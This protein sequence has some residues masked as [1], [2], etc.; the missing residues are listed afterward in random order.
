MAFDAGAVIGH[1]LLDTSNWERG[2]KTV[3]SSGLATQKVFKGLATGVAAAGAV[4]GAAFVSSVKKANE[5]QKSFAN[6]TTLVDTAQVDVQGMAKE[7]LALDGALGSSRELT[8]GLYQALSASVAPAKAVEFVADSAK[9]AKAALVDTNTAV[10]VITT[11]LNAYGLQAEEAGRVSDVLFTT[12]KR[13]KTTGVELSAT[14]G[15]I[16]PLA[17]N[18]NLSF[19]NLGASMA[20]ITR[21]GISSAE[22]TTQMQAVMT[23]LLK[24]TGELSTAMKAAG[25]ETGEAVTS[26]EN[27][28]AALQQIISK[29]D[30]SQEALAALFPNVRALRGA[31]ALT[32][33][34]ATGFT[35]DLAAMTLAAGATNEAFGKQ[36]LTFETL[37]NQMGTISIIAGNVGKVFVDQLAEGASKA[38]SGMIDF[39]LSGRAAEPISTIMGTISGSF[40]LLKTTLKP[41]VDTIFPALKDIGETTSTAIGQLTGKSDGASGAFSIFSGVISLSTSIIKVLVSQIT[42][43]IENIGNMVEAIRASGGVIGDFFAF[44]KGDREWADVKKGVTAATDAFKKFG[45]DLI[46]NVVDPFKTVFEEARTFTDRSKGLALGMELSYTS[47]FNKTKSG[48]K[49]AFYEMI[50]GQED[51]VNSILVGN[52]LIL[53]SSNTTSTGLINNSNLTTRMI[54]DN[55]E[56][57]R[58][59]ALSFSAEQITKLEELKEKYKE[60]AETLASTFGPVL[61]E[62]GTALVN[63][64]DGWDAFKQAGKSA[65]ASIVKSFAKMWALEA[66]AEFALGHIF[67]GIKLGAASVAA[68]TGAGIIE[69]LATGGVAR[70]PVIV[71]ENGPELMN[72]GTPSR[73]FSADETSA[74]MKKIDVNITN[75]VRNDNDIE[76]INRQF[77]RTLENVLR[78]IG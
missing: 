57:M 21:Q 18:M 76:L 47:A 41:I 8:E 58:V 46:G 71:G 43:A 12:I 34:G 69:G 50:T 33:D 44:L 6:V 53:Q 61:G 11:G 59:A 22:S 9:F 16:I 78:K 20:T 32:G 1:V 62:L 10:D 64:E 35:E 42:G 73:V 48:F 4:I 67:T 40:E 26:S 75:Y 65:I 17:A 37:K 55:A 74:M 23:A 39:V 70:G 36:E 27:F 77:G 25:F 54:I 7:L 63:A 66:A 72:V 68:Y 5:W 14:I 52:D 2:T 15:Q 38:A 30:G 49:S 13:G 3:K 31:L 51:F 29:T 60:T 19:E 56:K 28:Q 45:T 24:P